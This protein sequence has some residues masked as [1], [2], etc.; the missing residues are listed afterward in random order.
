MK[1]ILREKLGKGISFTCIT[2]KQFK[3]S[4]MSLNLILPL[5]QVNA[6]VCAVLPKVLRQG[7]AAYPD[8]GRL[9]AYLDSLYGARI[10]PFV[11]KRGEALCIGLISDV[12][13][14]RFANGESVLFRTAQLLENMLLEP[15]K[16]N[17]LF[18]SAYTQSEKENLKDEIR[19]QINDKRS[20]AL[21][22]LYE[23]M[24][25]KEAYGINVLGT[26]ELAEQITPESLTAA[27]EK[28]LRTAQIEL[29]YCGSQ[30]EQT[31]RAAF[32]TAFSS[33]ER[34]EIMP[35]TTE[36]IRQTGKV[37]NVI[38]E[39]DA[40]QGK[41][42]LG[43][44]TGITAKEPGYPAFM[45]FNCAFGGSTSSKLFLN[46]REKK[47]LCYYASST[48]DKLKGLMAVASGIENQNIEIARDEILFQLEEIQR[49]NLTDEELASAKK[50]LIYA[51][52]AAED[53]PVSLESF[54]LTNAVGQLA[55]SPADIADLLSQTKKKDVI[56][57]AQHI[58]LDTVYFL[59]GGTP[60]G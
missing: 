16:K 53:S 55:G 56:Q 28:I 48:T 31:V 13:D 30:P 37:R 32:L 38:E 7:T 42:S 11:R 49:G 35:V 27:Y 50:T 14:D 18:S 6:S 45:L 59:K 60:R 52:R 1:Q 4:C 19:A 44:R 25:D 58:Q 22:R 17:G 20:Y 41:L 34:Q 12:I 54:Y 2:T 21:T 57:A 24:C 23:I 51:F 5:G 47:S 29:F 26:P 39:M 9:G 15:Y 36:V 43:F 3:T 46:V 33:I 40:V 10:E 8:R